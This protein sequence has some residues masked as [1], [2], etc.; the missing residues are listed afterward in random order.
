[1]DRTREKITVKR[2]WDICPWIVISG[3]TYREAL[4]YREDLR[5]RGNNALY[6]HPQLTFSPNRRGGEK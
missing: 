4:T 5:R 1:M 3:A 6:P 2:T